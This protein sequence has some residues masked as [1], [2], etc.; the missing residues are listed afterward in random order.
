MPQLV[1][2]DGEIF[3]LSELAAQS[4]RAIDFRA[5]AAD[6]N[7]AK[8]SVPLSRDDLIGSND[9]AKE[10]VTELIERT[11]KLNFGSDAR[12]DELFEHGL[13]RGAALDDELRAATGAALDDLGVVGVRDAA[14]LVRALR[15]FEAPL[16]TTI[17]AERV[18]QLLSLIH[19]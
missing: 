12:R 5:D 11:A 15:W 19:I 14:R 6:A 4:C 13:P 17:L 2:S 16:P 7:T 9:L 1:T 3:E 18:A 10:R 8:I